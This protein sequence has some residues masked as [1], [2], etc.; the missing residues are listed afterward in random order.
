MIARRMRSRG[1]HLGALFL[2]AIA[3]LGIASGCGENSPSRVAARVLDRYRKTTGSKPLTASG[4]IRLR[5]A[6][7]GDASVTGRDEIVWAPRQFRET[8]SSADMTVVHGIQSGRAYYIDQDS[9]ARVVSDPVLR[10]LRTVSYTHLRAHE[11]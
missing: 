5:L 4:M 7:E 6:R 8:V 9:V 11:T 3:A 2:I 10:E 1:S